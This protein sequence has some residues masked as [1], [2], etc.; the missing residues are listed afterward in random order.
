MYINVY[1]FPHF[2][3][4]LSLKGHSFKTGHRSPLSPSP[5][6]AITH[7]RTI[8]KSPSVM[9]LIR[10]KIKVWGRASISPRYSL[11]YVCIL[12]QTTL[13]YQQGIESNQILFIHWQCILARPFSILLLV[14]RFLFPF[15]IFYK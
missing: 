12:L 5:R 6:I 13:P 9:N 15:V 7:P 2:T 8:I 10:K 3:S 11:S 1:I 14:V 4:K